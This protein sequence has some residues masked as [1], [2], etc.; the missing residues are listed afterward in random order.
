MYKCT[1]GIVP[2]QA[3]VYPEEDDPI[4][5]YGFAPISLLDCS[6]ERSLG[7]ILYELPD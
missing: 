7:A 2:G 4:W 6:N 1:A 3:G 5:R